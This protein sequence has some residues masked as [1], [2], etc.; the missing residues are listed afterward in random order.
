MNEVLTRDTI[1]CGTTVR[2]YSL[3]G[4]AWDSDLERLRRWHSEHQPLAARK[5]NWKSI[6]DRMPRIH[7][8]KKKAHE[9]QQE[10][11]YDTTDDRHP[12]AIDSA[13]ENLTKIR[14]V[15]ESVSARSRF[16]EEGR[17]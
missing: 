13:L 15:H 14:P 7:L 5:A 2:L 16:V 3:D 4:H 1:V 12:H 11:E 6:S 9:Q 10:R 8:A 17:V